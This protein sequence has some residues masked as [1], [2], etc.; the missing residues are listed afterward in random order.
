MNRRT[1]TLT[2]GLAGI[3]AATTALSGCAAL[4]GVF[5]KQQSAEYATAADAGEAG[6]DAE[7]IPADATDIRVTRSTAADAPDAVVLLASAADLAPGVCA[8]VERQSA[9]SYSIDGAPDVYAADT[10]FACGAWS[11]VAA[12]GGWYGWTPNHPHEAEQAPAAAP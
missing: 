10:V 5:T 7:W 2:L 12:D 1:A 6:I 4:E 9:P 3:V 11:V 8:E